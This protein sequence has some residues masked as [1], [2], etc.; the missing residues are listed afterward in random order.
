[1]YSTGN[2]KKSLLR[3]AAEHVV[4]GDVK[5]EKKYLILVF[6]LLLVARD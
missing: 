5:I 4:E 3:F 1:M 2:S 6:G